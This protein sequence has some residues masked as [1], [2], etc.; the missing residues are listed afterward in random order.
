LNIADIEAANGLAGVLRDRGDG[1]GTLVEMIVQSEA[2]H[3]R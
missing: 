3:A 1:L 2:F